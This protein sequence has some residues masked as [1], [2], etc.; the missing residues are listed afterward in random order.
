MA[1]LL[2]EKLIGFWTAEFPGG[3]F[4]LGLRQ[5]GGKILIDYRFRYYRDDKL[6]PESQD[7]MHWYHMESEAADRDEALEIVRGLGEQAFEDMG[8]EV[9]EVLMGPEGLE[10]FMKRFEALPSITKRK[11]N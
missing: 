1:I 9:H 3:N 8:I 7:E 11:L 10:E 2:D 4:A 6:F 5:D